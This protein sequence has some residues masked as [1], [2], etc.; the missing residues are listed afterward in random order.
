MSSDILSIKEQIAR[1][2]EETFKKIS[3]NSAGYSNTYKVQRRRR[4]PTTPE[5]LL[6]E[7]YQLPGVPE[8]LNRGRRR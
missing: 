8:N 3:A 6:A 7:I 2:V 1:N 5:P 4:T